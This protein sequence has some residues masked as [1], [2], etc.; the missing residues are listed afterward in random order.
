MQAYLQ[1]VYLVV[2]AIL[3]LITYYIVPRKWRY[4]VIL[5]F[6]LVFIFITSTYMGCFVILAGIITYVFAKIMGR[7]YEKLGEKKE[8]L[9]KEEFKLLKKKTKKANKG[10]LSI[11][12]IC[13]LLILIVL[14]YLNFFDSILNT[15]FKTNIPMLKILLPLGISY[16]TLMSIG[17][18]VDVYY[19]KV[20]CNNSFFQVL[21]FICY[22]PQ[23]LEGPIAK[24][25][26]I[27]KDLFE[28]NTFSYDSLVKGLERFLFG[29]FK[30]IVIADRLAILVGAIFGKDVITGYPVILGI[31]AF[32]F[33]LYAEFS[34]IIDMVS[35]ISK[36]FGI[37]LAQNFR[38]PFFSTSVGEFWRRWHI[39]LG[40]WFKEYVFYPLSM[41][42]PLVGLSKKMK[43]KLS[44]FFC[45]FLTS[46][47][48][49]LVVWSLTGLWHG[50]SLKYLVYGLYYYIIMVFETLFAYLY[51]N[52]KFK[53]QK[54]FKI[55]GLVKT[56]ILVNIGMLIFRANTLN[57]SLNMMF[58]IF[59]SSNLN[60]LKVFSIP[61]IVISFI[62]LGILL[63]IGIIKE[64]GMDIFKLLH[65]YWFVHYAII[66][67]L[68]MGTIIFGAYGNGY[69]PPDPI[70]GG[71]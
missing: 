37:N 43:G 25:D 42:K 24:Y 13:L 10:I 52:Q 2:F 67:L 9:E 11:A 47:L 22:F 70:Y 27:S 41:S 35:G 45:S 64:K 66:I 48:A 63:V 31:I 30:K 23:L 54:W 15:I 6:S 59:K 7:K 46:Q 44:P 21:L 29:L 32:T 14:K 8:S 1:I 38:Q 34:G 12:I 28:G 53:D 68:I 71:F 20:N 18:L 69:L 36:M 17:Y 26:V 16:Y 40:T 58:N 19:Q 55:F 51:R 62:T 4:L 33:Q 56:F 57:D 60:I 5:F 61:E 3:V 65:K 49:L 39:S 50:A